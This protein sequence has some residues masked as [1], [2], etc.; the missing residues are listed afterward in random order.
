MNE[1]IIDLKNHID[2]LNDVG[3][4]STFFYQMA[5]DSLI[6]TKG[7]SVQ[8]RRAMAQAHLLKNSPIAIHPFELICGS[9]SEF[10]P[11]LKNVPSYNEQYTKAKEILDN[12]SLNKNEYIDHNSTKTGVKTFEEDFTTKKSRW[13]LMSRVHHDANISYSDLQKLIL[14]MQELYDS[15]LEKYEI[16]RELERSFKIDYSKYKKEIDSLPWFAANHLNLNYAGIMN[17]GLDDISK[18]ITEKSINA[19]DEQKEFY[20][21]AKIVI[22]AL[23]EFILRY[24]DA[25]FQAAQN[26]NNERQKE[27][28]E[29]A[30]ICKKIAHSRAETF[31]EGIQFIWLL[32]IA[33]S[34]T[35]G[36]ALSFGRLDQYMFELYNN[37]IKN[38]IISRD[39]AKDILCCLWLKVNEPKM[40]TVQSLTVGGI[41]PEGEN[42]ANDLTK[43]CLEV[44]ELLKL[45]YP[46]VGVRFNAK[47]PEWLY[48]AVVDSIKNG[49]GQPMIM[50]DD[51]WISNLKRL[52]YSDN[53]A[54]DYYNMGC[55]EIMIPGK[56][57]N[58]GVTEPIAFPMIFEDV[59]NKFRKNAITLNS[60]DEF[61]RAYFAKLRQLVLN[62]KREA[63]SKTTDMPNKCYDPLASLMIDNCLEK[64]KDMFQGGSELGIHWSFYAYGLGTAADSM[65]AIKKFVY[66]EKLISIEEMSRLLQTNFKD[67]EKIHALLSNNTPC[68]G[69]DIDEADNI[70]NEILSTFNQMVFELNNK[71]NPN[72]YVSTL[73]GYFFHIY[74]G[75][76]TGATANGRKKAESFSDSMGPSQGK[77]VA[78]P[79]KML[80]SVLKLN[81]NN[82]N[83]GYALNI[84]INPTLVKT[85]AGAAA[86]KALIKTYIVDGGPQL[87]VNFV[88]AETLK[89]AQLEPGKYRNL[90]VRIGGYC[91][92]FINLD[93][94]L[95]NEIITRTIHGI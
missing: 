5:Y 29:I 51:V 41:T 7:K 16:G 46:N 66:E 14:Q 18:D 54:N 25:L 63:D 62:G 59:F 22:S 79:T 37:D 88:D 38:N 30:Y 4:R 19:D 85:K 73:F 35:W 57:P 44:T 80:N 94:A 53:Y 56:Q 1:R 33:A 95:Q 81:H 91:E 9:L 39:K 8:Y 26:E 69:N 20:D 10:C 12:Y 70:A 49:C 3:V 75:E 74:H 68:Y 65:T 47:N 89:K 42:A 64:G 13:A 87:Q 23:S 77:D 48:D 6:L 43:L 71:G 72:K 24:S 45:P 17:K 52:G 58:W 86:L 60:F 28:T 83:G 15:K 32:H 50:N 11:P 76:I 40:R 61:K 92:Y 67:N 90:I 34:V 84:K 31:Y 93:H 55:V 27:L 36:S 2:A 21:C 78:G 82:V